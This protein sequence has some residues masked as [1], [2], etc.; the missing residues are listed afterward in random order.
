MAYATWNP[1]DKSADITLSGSNL[2]ATK[3][4]AGGVDAVRGTQG[5]STGKWYF[6]ITLSGASNTGVGLGT[7]S[8]SLTSYTAG[9]M[10]TY[11]MSAQ[12]FDG[13]SVTGYGA[14]WSN[15]DVISVL[16]DADGGNI[17]FWKNGASQ[18]TAFTSV[19]GT[20]YAYYPAVTQDESATVNFGASAFTYTPPEGYSGWSDANEQS[21][22][23]DV[24]I[25]VG[26]ESPNEFR[27][28]EFPSDTAIEVGVS[29]PTEFRSS[30]RS[31]DV[32]VEIGVEAVHSFGSVIGPSDIPIEVG[33]AASISFAAANSWTG[34]AQWPAF[35]VTGILSAELTTGGIT[36]PL[37]TVEA[38]MDSGAAWVAEP[39]WPPLTVDGQMQS[40]TTITAAMSYAYS[41]SAS[42]LP[43]AAFEYT[44]DV[45]GTLISGKAFLGVLIAPGFTAEGTF[46]QDG[47]YT[48]SGTYP[49]W[50]VNGALSPESLLS[51]ALAYPRPRVEAT[52]L[53]GRDWTAVA[54]FPGYT[55]TSVHYGEYLLA[56]AVEYSYAME[57]AV[58]AAVVNQFYTWAMNAA[59]RGLTRYNNFSFNSYAVFK[60]VPLSAGAAGIV[61]HDASN[62]DDG[63]AIVAVVR[64]G[65]EGFGTTFNKRLPRLYVT[66]EGL[67]DLHV[68]TFTSADG[69]RT[70]FLPYNGVMGPQVRRV[71]INRGPKSAHWQL[72]VSNPNGEDFTLSALQANTERT[73]RRVL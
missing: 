25:E 20:L 6:E 53:V 57:A 16:W 44:Y 14:S 68:S 65:K 62:D 34:L 72:E 51:A 45:T 47:Q 64:T 12:K 56:G 38:T 67:G 9:H 11:F 40:G 21:K 43:A 1:S 35:A 27:L 37:F 10:W 63:S 8:A 13:S 70:Y 23:G 39:A 61:P 58:L 48:G 73:R 36:W 2:V 26:V 60:D 30:V 33:V 29:S 5:K 3:T 22:T 19:S 15:G 49:S 50:R 54:S 4:T 71:P 32:A 24:A 7:S 66:Y 69:K 42:T 59:N 18:G 52:L 17:I 41:M 28:F 46:V 55:V 31:S